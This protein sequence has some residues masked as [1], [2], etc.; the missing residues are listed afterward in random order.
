MTP[1]TMRLLSIEYGRLDAIHGM[2]YH[3]PF[4]AFAAEYSKSFTEHSTRAKEGWTS[5]YTDPE[6]WGQY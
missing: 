3:P 1:H 2:G 5:S 4:P 6:N